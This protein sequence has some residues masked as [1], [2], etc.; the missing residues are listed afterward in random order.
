MLGRSKRSITTAEIAA[1]WGASREAR[2]E[3]RLLV[4]EEQEITASAYARVVEPLRRAYE[5]TGNP[6][7]AL[8]AIRVLRPTAASV[9]GAASNLQYA[10]CPRWA[11][12]ALTRAAEETSRAQ[13]EEAQRR[14]RSMEVSIRDRLHKEAGGISDRE[15]HRIL[16]E[17]FGDD[18][19]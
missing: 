18:A 11:I 14:W 13:L 10:H 12:E 4:A 6:A 15:A 2:I 1:A 19:P 16:L 5:E 9:R 8:L 7:F 3:M 17:W